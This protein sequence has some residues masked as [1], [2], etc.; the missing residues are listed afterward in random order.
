MAHHTRLLCLT[1]GDRG[2]VLHW[3]GDRRRFR[4]IPVEEV[5]ATGAGDIFAAAFFTR[6]WR[7]RDPR[8]RRVLRPTLRRIQ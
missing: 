6:L 1:E 4:P 2:A 5:D 3:H 8:R 7:T